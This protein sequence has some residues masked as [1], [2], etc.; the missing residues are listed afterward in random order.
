MF[1]L[2]YN[3]STTSRLFYKVK[4]QLYLVMGSTES[5]CCLNTGKVI[6]EWCKQVTD[7]RDAP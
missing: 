5:S 1:H 2:K 3:L 4:R 7:D 6:F